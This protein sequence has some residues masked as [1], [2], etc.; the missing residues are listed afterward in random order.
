MRILALDHVHLTAPR[1]SEDRLR[2][3]YSDLLG[4]REIPKPASLQARGGVWFDC[5]NLQLHIGVEDHPANEHSRRHVALRVDSLAAVR[6]QLNAR[7]IPIEEDT[8]PIEGVARFYCRDAV[9]NRVE[10][11]Q[12][13]SSPIML[14]GW[15]DRPELVDDYEVGEGDVERVA[16]SPDGQWLA[17]GTAVNN[18]R[19]S[20]PRLS[21]WRWGEASEPNTIIELADSL[22]ELAFAP[23]GPSL[24]AITADGSLE[25]WRVE[26][27]ESERFA[28]LPEGSAGL[29]YSEDGSLL[30]VGSENGVGIFRPDLDYLTTL[31]PDLGAINALAFDTQDVL[32]VSGEATRVQLWQ[33]KP[34]QRSSWELLGHESPLIAM[35]FHP[36]EPVLAGIT[37]DGELFYWNINEA[38]ESPNPLGDDVDFN[39]LAFSPAERGERLA[40]GAETGQIGLWEW[41]TKTVVV[42]LDLHSAVRTLVFT[43]DGQ[44]LV[45]GGADGRLRVW[46]VR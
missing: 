16:L 11:V 2:A 9:G 38:P 37:D 34:V 45:A 20:A 12:W 41:S 1:G 46:R 22:W 5:G 28:E 33:I 15:L 26:D 36:G 30:A 3:F 21:V 44:H 32:A 24:V 39:A 6:E 23:T 27:F 31:W 40:T 42:E 29:A 17:A 4:L 19:Q 13:V 43:P 8:A 25:T 10:F 7:A 35:R 14:G 18:A